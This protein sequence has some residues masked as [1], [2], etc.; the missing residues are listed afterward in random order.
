MIPVV[1]IIY[2]DPNHSIAEICS[3]LNEAFFSALLGFISSKPAI[4][5]VSK[6]SVF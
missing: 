6:P 1:S 3:K 2:E 4:S 5:C